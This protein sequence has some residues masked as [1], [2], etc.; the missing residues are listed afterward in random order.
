MA[1]KARVKNEKLATNP[2]TMP[3]GRRLPLVT[4]PVRMTGKTGRIQGDNIVTTPARN[5]KAA[6]KTMPTSFITGM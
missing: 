5:E 4:A 2:L 3:Q 1:A 6:S